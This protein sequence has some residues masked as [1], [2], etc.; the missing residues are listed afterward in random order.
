MNRVVITG[1]GV[2][3]PIGIGVSA[4]MQALKRGQCGV[5]ALGEA[6]NG[7][8]DGTYCRL[9]APVEAELD[10]RSI[11]RKQ[12]RSMGRGTVFAQ[13]AANEAL[14]HSGFPL[15][16]MGGGRV[17]VMIGSTITSPS[18]LSDFYEDFLVSKSV[19]QVPANGFFRVMGNSSAANVANCLGVTGRVH[20]TPAACASGVVAL[21]LGFE[22]IRAGVQDAVICGGVEELHP[23]TTAIFDTVGAASMNF[24]N[25]PELSPAP[26]DKDRDGTVCGEGAGVLL[27]ESEAHAAERGAVVLGRVE[28][29]ASTADAESLAHPGVPAMVNCMRLAL[30]DAGVEAADVDYISAHGTGTREGDRAEAKAITSVFGMGPSV[31]SLKGYL[32]HTL[33]AS[34]AIEAIA[35]LEMMRGGFLIPTA[36]LRTIDPECEGVN[37]VRT[38]E[39][40]IISRAMKCSFGF[41]GANGAVVL[42]ARD[43]R[44]EG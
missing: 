26:F 30:A 15:D 5:R 20:S 40:I 31:S 32:G 24:N 34:G 4:L 16:E 43:E 39:K 2:V 3:S 19:R 38:L 17:G 29:F 25:S 1:Y 21:G 28:G 35:T 6:W 44:M 37:H 11:P 36:K 22:L 7:D 23:S 12:R 27:I 13:L 18:S 8:I 9:G 41:G 33:G 42:G 14:R 10:L